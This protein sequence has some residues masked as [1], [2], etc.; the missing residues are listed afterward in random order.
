MGKPAEQVGPFLSAPLALAR[1]LG[2]Q[3]KTIPLVAVEIVV[4]PVIPLQIERAN[5]LFIDVIV[6]RVLFRRR[7]R[8]RR[9]DQGAELVDEF[10]IIGALRSALVAP[11]SDEGFGGS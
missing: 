1:L 6:E 5:P 7:F 11:I 4:P 9:T 2:L 3:N 8:L 10:L